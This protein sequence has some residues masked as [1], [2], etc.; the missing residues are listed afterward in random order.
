VAGQL[1]VSLGGAVMEG[2]MPFTLWFHE[3]CTQPARVVLER[4]QQAEKKALGEL[5]IY[6]LIRE[7]DRPLLWGVYFFFSPEGQC[8]YVGKNSA[9]KF[10]ERI[11]V[12]LSLAE[13]DWMNHLV[14]RMCRYEGLSCLADAAEAARGHTL[15][16]MPVSQEQKTQIAALEK[17]FRL[18]AEPKYNALPRRKRH[19]RIVLEAS[20]TEVL[21]SMRSR[22]GAPE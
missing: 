15:L 4:V 9:R 7:G 18:F 2:E 5:R 11:P 22:P 21:A 3:V 16:L 12:H 6:D 20:L 14:K 1:C 10:V 13:E 17:F 8:L 19:S